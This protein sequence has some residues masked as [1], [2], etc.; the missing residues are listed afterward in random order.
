MREREFGAAGDR[1]VVEEFLRGEEASFMAF[2][3]GTRFFPMAPSQ[4][5]KAIYDGDK[6]P[7][8]GGMGAYSIDRILTPEI[9]AR[10]VEEI[11]APTIKGMAA[12]GHPYRGILYAG[13]MLTNRGPKVLEFNVRFG[14]PETQ[15]VLPRL[16]SDLLPILEATARGDLSSVEA[17]W[18]DDAT[19]CVVISSAGYPGAYEKGKEITGLE[20]A[21]EDKDTIVFHAGTARR[22]GRIFT[23]GGRVLGVTARAKSLDEAILRAYE[24]VNK[25]HFDGMYYR[26]DIA[27]KGLR[28]IQG[29]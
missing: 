7:N 5:H 28:K 13:L 1:V 9:R 11:L 16:E 27:A 12:E 3:D 21:A 18:N 25:I 23:S 8:T 24:G 19:V 4:D 2:S 20:M 26:R 10:A 22:D 15:V 29:S 14:D 6:G 17:C